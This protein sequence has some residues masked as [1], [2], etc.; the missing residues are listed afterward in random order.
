MIEIYGFKEKGKG[1]GEGRPHFDGQWKGS[2]LLALAMNPMFKVQWGSILFG[3][4][5]RF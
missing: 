2:S 1:G 5:G 3:A 4:H